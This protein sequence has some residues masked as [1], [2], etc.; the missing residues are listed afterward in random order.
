MSSAG[1]PS[2]VPYRE[3]R[4]PAWSGGVS[5]QVLL[6]LCSFSFFLSALF[7]F[8]FFFG[9]FFGFLFLFS[10]FLDPSVP[11]L[12]SR[13]NLNLGTSASA[14]ALPSVILVLSVVYA[15]FSGS[16]CWRKKVGVAPQKPRIP[17]VP[18]EAEVGNRDLGAWRPGL[19]SP[20]EIV[21]WN[22]G[23]AQVRRASCHFSSLSGIADPHN[24]R[25]KPISRCL[26]RSHT[27][28]IIL[29]HRASQFA[30]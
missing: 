5:V 10:Q 13:S 30:S 23:H 15:C 2:I 29:V 14:F 22:N 4:R 24:R 11:W 12:S 25:R 6:S 7:F 18:H 3:D 20:A 21:D 19:V 8:F 26:H 17:G 1:W 9:F 28:H 27:D 16:G